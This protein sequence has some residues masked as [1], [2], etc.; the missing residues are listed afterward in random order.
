MV[1][2]LFRKKLL[3]VLAIGNKKILD[4]FVLFIEQNNFIKLKNE[5]YACQPDDKAI[6]IQCRY[7]THNILDDY[8]NYVICSIDSLSNKKS[9]CADF[10]YNKRHRNRIYQLYLMLE[11]LFNHLVPPFSDKE[12]NIYVQ[13]PGL[14]NNR[15]DMFFN[16]DMLA[17]PA[18]MKESNIYFDLIN[19]RVL[20]IKEK[21][22]SE[23]RIEN[24]SITCPAYHVD[25]RLEITICKD[26]YF[27]AKDKIIKTYL[28]FI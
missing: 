4:H 2:S 17:E 15:I 26:H 23:N 3:E 25:D 20:I 12:K 8:A 22:K 13:I 16:K 9:D 24:I 14:V 7:I 19:P 10:I 28:Q 11:S 6:D 27:T 21:I 5:G 18:S 1:A